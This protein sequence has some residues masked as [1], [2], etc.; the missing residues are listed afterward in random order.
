MES[1]ALIVSIIILGRI[2]FVSLCVAL[3][4]T[5]LKHRFVD[6]LLQARP[7]IPSSPWFTLGLIFVFLGLVLHFLTFWGN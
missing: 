2:A 1:L 5:Y 6:G 3:V 7:G 4:I